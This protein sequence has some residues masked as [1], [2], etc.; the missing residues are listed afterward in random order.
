[1]SDLRGCAKESRRFNGAASHAWGA[2]RADGVVGEAAS[3]CGGDWTLLVLMFFARPSTLRM[4]ASAPSLAVRS[5]SRK[6]LAPN[7]LRRPLPLWQRNLTALTVHSC[8]S[9]SLLTNH[10]NRGDRI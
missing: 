10:L 8:R 6:C 4:S 1:M 5:N 7:A 9:K 3:N 2:W